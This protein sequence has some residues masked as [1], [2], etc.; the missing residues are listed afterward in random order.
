MPPPYRVKMSSSADCKNIL[1]VPGP[2]PYCH[3][4]IRLPHCSPL[5]VQYEEPRL[6]PGE[7]WWLR[8]EPWWSPGETWESVGICRLGY[9]G[10]QRYNWSVEC[11]YNKYRLEGWKCPTSPH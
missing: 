9:H 4:Y 5:R 2:W 3:R 1:S 10:C 6:L 11:K 7:P 8:G